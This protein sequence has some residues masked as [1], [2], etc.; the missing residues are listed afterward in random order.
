MADILASRPFTQCFSGA[1]DR[2]SRIGQR[3]SPAPACEPVH[4]LGRQPPLPIVEAL[5]TIFQA[6]EFSV[7]CLRGAFDVLTSV[8]WHGVGPVPGCDLGG[9]AGVGSKV[10]L[11]DKV[12]AERFTRSTVIVL[13]GELN[14]A[15]ATIE[16]AVTRLVVAIA[17]TVHQFG[18]L[19]G[20]A[21]QGFASR[22]IK[23]MGP[24]APR[25]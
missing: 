12:Q 15:P 21:L 23:H 1:C 9:V 8:G 4:D 13:A 20:A 16:P 18:E 25:P 11:A 2:L 24:F 14:I 6:V 7:H 22:S 5:L 17:A 19:L 10:G 3:L